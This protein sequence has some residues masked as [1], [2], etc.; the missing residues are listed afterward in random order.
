MKNTILKNTVHTLFVICICGNAVAQRGN[1]VPPSP[2]EISM[3]KAAAPDV[4]LYTGR[5]DLSIPLYT[6]K[7]Q[8]I[9]ANISLKYTGGSGIKVQEIAGEAGLGWA[10]VAGG[11]I[12]RTIKGSF[13]WFGSSY[14]LKS[15]DLQN[16][17]PM[18]KEGLSRTRGDGLGSSIFVNQ[19][20]NST[21][22]GRISFHKGKAYFMDQQGF[23]I[24]Q[25]GISSTTG[26]WIIADPSGNRYFF[27]STVNERTPKDI[28]YTTSWYLTKVT[29]PNGRSIYFGY[30]K[31]GRS[32]YVTYYQRQK[33]SFSPSSF[34]ALMSPLGYVDNIL[35]FIQP[36]E[37][38][39]LS[40]ISSGTANVRFSY[41]QRT[42]FNNSWAISE[43]KV[44]DKQ[45]KL[46]KRYRF[47]MDYFKSDDGK[48]EQRLKLK[49]LREDNLPPTVFHY[50]EEENLP[51]RGSPKF[52]HWGYYNNN[53]SEQYFVSYGANKAPNL[54]KAQANML[55]GV[56]WPTG[57]QTSYV[58]EMNT[59]NR[60]HKKYI[61]AGL[62]I[63]AVTQCTAEGDTLTTKYQY[64]NEDGQSSGLFHAV[65][66]PTEGYLSTYEYK[67]YM[68]Q[69][70]GLTGGYITTEYSSPISKTLDLDGVRIGYS[71]VAVIQ[72]DNSREVYIFH[73]Y[74]E[75][76]DEILL[77]SYI[78]NRTFYPDY[79]R[80]FGLNYVAPEVDKQF[81]FFTSK[82]PYRGRVKQKLWIDALGRKLR[83][84]NYEYDVY[85]GVSIPGS[86][87]KQYA[88][89][90]DS[91]TAYTLDSPYEPVTVTNTD[92]F[93]YFSV[94]YDQAVHSRLARE[95]ETEYDPNNGRAL[96][97]RRTDY[98]YTRTAFLSKRSEKQADGTVLA[99]TYGYAPDFINN[100]PVYQQ[101]TAQ[102]M[103]API[104]EQN[105]WLYRDGQPAKLIG[106]RANT[107]GLATAGALPAQVLQLKAGGSKGNVNG[108]GI[109]NSVD[110][111]VV[112]A[113][114]SY[115]ENANL[116]SFSENQG[117]NQGYIW[118]Y[119]KQYPVVKVVNAAN[120]A[121][122][123][124]FFYEG[125]EDHPI[126]PQLVN[127]N[128]HTGQWNWNGSYSLNINL[129]SGRSYLIQWW[130]FDGSRWNFNESPFSGSVTLSGILDDIRVFPTDAQMTTYTYRP[131]LGIA[132]QT[133]T[134][135]S[136]IYYEYDD[137]GR[138]STVRDNDK[139]IL[140]HYEYE[141]T[142]FNQSS[143]KPSLKLYWN[144]EMVSS[145]VKNNCDPGLGSYSQF[146]YTVAAGQYASIWSQA[147]ADS[148]AMIALEQDGQRMA[149]QR[150]TCALAMNA[151]M[152]EPNWSRKFYPALGRYCFYSSY[153]Y[154]PTRNEP[155]F[156]NFGQTPE[157]IREIVL[158][159]DTQ[160]HYLYDPSSASLV[161]APN[162]YYNKV[163][164]GVM[165]I[166]LIHRMEN[167]KVV[168][169]L[170]CGYMRDGGR[171]GPVN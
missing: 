33:N 166:N 123:D 171:I 98:E 32:Y 26:E 143:V 70:T 137:S 95:V 57:G 83:S 74:N 31:S 35:D 140:Q 100:G 127:V 94:Y 115:D 93:Y 113:Y 149:N 87:V 122:A 136:T 60:G 92:Y 2:N 101:M 104:I 155:F 18:L 142:P 126:S 15:P 4:N 20:I 48:E 161:L 125:F 130:N 39:R 159:F 144:Q 59:Y 119:G 66:E 80:N 64:L 56:R 135:G 36:Y 68:D 112:T 7:E 65:H 52:D 77:G 54:K 156:C 134:R 163:R 22:G 169:I 21:V 3:I 117:V 86:E 141:H 24:V 25:D 120:D 38:I 121:Q 69:A 103:L 89:A 63:A 139:K 148:L 71:R 47:D 131:L 62:R 157:S 29:S 11:V 58:Y 23:E 116:L 40:S 45:E 14:P 82:A 162:G 128:P 13:D 107:Y 27:G 170:R 133:D 84:A 8:S 152:L 108:S 43:I 160:T 111:K 53:L 81:D 138:L 105:T 12:T 167:G 154:S 99:T 42:D 5:A 150:G 49:S 55:V 147:D 51:E 37:D 88:T 28:E 158:D 19:V 146:N 1:F 76:P 106:S 90:S 97:S 34:S 165:G 16:Y 153:Y 118:G 44:L 17:I 164:N 96:T 85:K 50:N 72:P 41:I 168:E 102:N 78:H 75:F 124:E 79:I 10:L 61:G 46:V 91:F 132:S 30:E 9:A 109:S 151:M 67:S 73:D 6:V 114:S 129:R 145:F 110:Y